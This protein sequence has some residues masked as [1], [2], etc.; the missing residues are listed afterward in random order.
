MENPTPI[1]CTVCWQGWIAAEDV[2]QIVDSDLAAG[3][4]LAGEPAR[5]AELSHPRVRAFF[6][7]WRAISAEYVLIGRVSVGSQARVDFQLFD[8]TRQEGVA[9][10]TVPGPVAELRMLA[11][12]V[13][14]SVYETLTGIPGAFATRLLYV[15]VTRNPNGKIFIA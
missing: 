7:D 6:R 4:V 8:T 9:D 3:S 1:A 12:R 10:G 5:H 14:D 2:A 11:H 15:S 13:S